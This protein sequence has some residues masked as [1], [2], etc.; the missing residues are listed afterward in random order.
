MFTHSFSCSQYAH[1]VKIC[2]SLTTHTK[3]FLMNLIKHRANHISAKTNSHKQSAHSDLVRSDKAENH[4]GGLIFQR[5]HFN[6]M[7]LVLHYEVSEHITSICLLTI[8][9][10]IKLLHY[11]IHSCINISNSNKTGLE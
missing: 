9:Y 8:L 5:L 2:M 7:G 11:L 3:K 4:T 6:L 1:S 10:A